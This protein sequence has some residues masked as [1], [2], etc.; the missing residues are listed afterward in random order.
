[1]QVILLIIIGVFLIYRMM[2][3]ED[4]MNKLERD[5]ENHKSEIKNSLNNEPIKNNSE[6]KQ[7]HT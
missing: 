5:V 4:R 1:M 2:R 7:F 6:F 3:V